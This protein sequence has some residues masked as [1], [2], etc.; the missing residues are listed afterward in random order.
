M[1]FLYKMC[2]LRFIHAESA[3]LIQSFICHADGRFGFL[4]LLLLQTK[5]NEHLSSYLLCAHERDPGYTLRRGVFGSGMR[6][7][8]SASR[9]SGTSEVMPQGPAS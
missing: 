5:L 8:T 6:P 1:L 2:R 9:L 4:Q 7:A 3:A